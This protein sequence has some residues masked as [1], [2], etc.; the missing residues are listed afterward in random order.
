MIFSSKK[1]VFFEQLLTIS[2]NVKKSSDFFFHYEIKNVAD[3]KELSSVMKE[4]ESRGDTYIHKLIV[5]L[6]KTFIT[7]IER[8]DILQLGV[9]MDDVLDGLE[10]CAAYFEMFSLTEID[11][12]MRKFLEHIHQST[13]EITTALQLLSNKKLHDMRKHAIEIK[14]HES[15]CDDI[16]RKSIKHLFVVEKDP[17][18]VIQYKE[19]YEMLEGVAD[20]CQDI[21]NTIESIIMRNA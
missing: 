15:K 1:D 18:K 19:I 2:E 13:I 5:A 14:D 17:I 9:K 7:P 16:L 20:T 11:D 6:N 8:E 10:Q 12:F 21:A 3:L 4:Y